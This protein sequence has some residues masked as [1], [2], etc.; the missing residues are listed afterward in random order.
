[1]PP[2]PNLLSGE[3]YIPVALRVILMP[4]CIGEPVTGVVNM[5]PTAL[6]HFPHVEYFLAYVSDNVHPSIAAEK[7]KS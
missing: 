6:T 2:P 7:P 4:T 1:M 3:G 5:C